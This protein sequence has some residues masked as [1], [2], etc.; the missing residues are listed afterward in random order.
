MMVDRDFWR[1]VMQ[2]ASMTIERREHTVSRSRTHLGAEEEMGAFNEEA[3]AHLDGLYNFA[4]RMTRN[5]QDAAD[6]VQ[7]TYLRGLRFRRQ[8]RPGTNFRAWLFRILR[9]AFIDSYWR[10]SREPAMEDMDSERRSA[11]RA[12][13]EGVRGAG[14]GPLDQLVRL[15][16]REALEQLSEPFRGAIILS[17]IHGFSVREISEIMT[18]PENTVKTRLFRGR[19]ILRELLQDYAPESDPDA[20]SLAPVAGEDDRSSEGARGLRGN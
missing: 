13:V 17:D 8:F 2:S 3:L 7:E 20:A 19:R 5:E 16:L 9:N 11:T 14:A 12:E 6:L 1:Q 4:L 10:Q 15:D 18:C